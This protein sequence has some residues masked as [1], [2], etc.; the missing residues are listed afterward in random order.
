MSRILLEDA[1]LHELELDLV[2]PLV[3]SRGELSSRRIIVLEATFEIR[4][5]SVVGVGEAAPLPS[6]G[7]E[8]YAA[9]LE[10]LQQVESGVAFEPGEF[11][12]AGS[13]LDATPT[14]RFAVE[15]AALDATAKSRGVPL[16]KLLSADGPAA[17]EV[18]L[19]STLNMTDD[20]EVVAQ[21]AVDAVDNG[22][23]CLKLKVGARPLE[24]DLKAVS[25]IRDTVGDTIS[26][27]LDANGVWDE[28]EAVGALEALAPHSIEYVE[29]PVA[30]GELEALARLSSTSD[31]PIAA[32][33]S[34]VAAAQARRLIDEKMV[35]VLVLKPMALGGLVPALELAEQADAAGLRVTFTSLM[36]S[37]IGRSAVAHAAASRPW[38]RG[39][40]GIATGAWFATDIAESA[41]PIVNGAFQLDGTPGLGREFVL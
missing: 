13:A 21:R 9:C 17:A 2:E 41:D 15:L 37:A 12:P 32:D 38:L 22:F 26:I 4:G 8:G 24:D 20:P 18:L 5:A 33:E 30:A 29:Q 25:R 40:H 16:A 10:A 39:A 14:A 19:N 31:I 36:D 1:T 7:T 28:Q 23:R 27:R 35:D 11:V 6:W 3:T 34:V